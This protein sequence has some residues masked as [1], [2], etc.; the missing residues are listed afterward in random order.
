MIRHPVNECASLHRRGRTRLDEST[1]GYE[2]HGVEESSVNVEKRVFNNV[3][4]SD[5]RSDYLTNT[6]AATTT[7]LSTKGISLN[8]AH[9]DAFVVS[10]K[11]PIFKIPHS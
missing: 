2:R 1:S 8:L 6:N 4:L 9:D 11:I 5:R 7:R 3:V 10:L